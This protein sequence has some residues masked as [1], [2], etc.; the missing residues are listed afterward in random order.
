[1]CI[2]LA[3]MENIGPLFQNIAKF[4]HQQNITEFYARNMFLS[5]S[6]Y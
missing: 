3:N 6:K 5:E 1:M 4:S 2:A